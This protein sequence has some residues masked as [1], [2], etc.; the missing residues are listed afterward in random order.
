MK[1]NLWDSVLKQLESDEEAVSDYLAQEYKNV[2]PFDAKEI[3]KE[4]LL[5]AY[6]NLGIQD[7]QQLIQKHGEDAVNEYIYDMTMLQRRK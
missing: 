2:R 1:E 6:E 5:W 4:D 7:M 3:P